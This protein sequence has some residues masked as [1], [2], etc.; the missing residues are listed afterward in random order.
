MKVYSVYRVHYQTSKIEFVGKVME[1]RKEERHNNPADMLRYAE[2]LYGKSF[3]SKL[4]VSSG[5]S[6]PWHSFGDA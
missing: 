6:P 1:R 5:T 4:V 3:D 2:K